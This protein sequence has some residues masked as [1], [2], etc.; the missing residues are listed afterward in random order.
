MPSVEF[1]DLI[2]HNTRP[3]K[4]KRLCAWYQRV[5]GADNFYIEIQNNG[6]AIQKECEQGAVDIARRMGL[7]LVATSDAHYLTQDDAPAH[8]ILLCINTGRT[9]DDPNRMRFENNQFHVREQEE[10]YAAMPEHAEALATTVRIADLVEENYG[11]L[12]LGSRQFPSFQPP[13]R[14]TPEDYLRELCE[15]GMR[16]RYGQNPPAEA[17]DRLEHELGIICRM[18]FASYF[19]IVWDFVRFAREKAIPTSA[20]GSALR[21]ASRE[22]FALSEPC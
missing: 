21:A 15:Q 4:P 16:E 10:M 12:N 13:D 19:L 9:V 22:L 6:I 8:D 17:H 2:L 3:R 11:S 20:R 1:S 7:P 5:F 14:K 18:G